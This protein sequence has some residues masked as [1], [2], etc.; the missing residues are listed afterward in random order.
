M[1]TEQPNNVPNT[2]ILTPQH[3]PPSS[4]DAALGESI[5]QGDSDAAVFISADC[6]DAHNMM[7]AYLQKPQMQSAVRV[8]SPVP[9]LMIVIGT[10]TVDGEERKR[11]FM[12]MMNQVPG[13]VSV[14]P[15]RKKVKRRALMFSGVL[16]SVCMRQNK[17]DLCIV[18]FSDLQVIGARYPWQ[19]FNAPMCHIDGSPMTAN[20]LC[21]HSVRVKDSN[22]V[23]TKER[24]PITIMKN[25]LVTDPCTW[26]LVS[27]A[28]KFGLMHTY[29][30]E[31]GSRPTLMEYTMSLL[32]FTRL[33]PAVTVARR[34]LPP[35]DT[36]AESASSALTT[37]TSSGSPID[38][39]MMC[40]VSALM[41]DVPYELALTALKYGAAEKECPEFCK[42]LLQCLSMDAIGAYAPKSLPHFMTSMQERVRAKLRAELG[43]DETVVPTDDSQT[44]ESSVAE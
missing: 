28:G 16:P 7:R 6:D 1:A 43:R 25:V 11:L 8:P 24:R 40:A 9:G 10:H 38:G 33:Q 37:T 12:V 2:V 4:N 17:T 27:L 32:P 29:G 15:S 18:N 34:T 44:A 22:G 3:Q 36:P 5:A 42:D 39:N 21:M 31:G 13:E 19:S 26:F 30:D 41:V 35:M 23:R 14:L 20:E